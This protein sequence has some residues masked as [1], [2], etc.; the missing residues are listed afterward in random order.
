MTATTIALLL[1]LLLLPLLVLVWASESTE[2]RTRRLASYGW[3][4]R[5]IADHLHITRLPRPHGAC[6]MITNPWINRITV[7]VVMFAIYA[8]GYAGGRDQAT[9]RFNH[10]AC[11]TNLK[12]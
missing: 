12:P 1:A 8:A 4:Q 7:L 2:Q 9:L 11:N 3:S 6:I 10:S 5:R